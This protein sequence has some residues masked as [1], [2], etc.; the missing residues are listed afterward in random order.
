[1]SRSESGVLEEVL[2]MFTV[3]YE[4]LKRN[5]NLCLRTD[6]QKERV[7]WSRVGRS[8]MWIIRE[9]CPTPSSLSMEVEEG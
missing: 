3:Q 4:G 2:L 8:Q 9:V 6:A 1:M 7:G 5:K